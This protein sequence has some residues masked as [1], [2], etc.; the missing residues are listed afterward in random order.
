MNLF[1]YLFWPNPAGWQY[2]DSRV[3]MLLGF[4][5]FLIVLSFAIRYWRRGIKNPITKNLSKSWSAA[6]FWFGIVGIIFVASRVEMIQ[7]L[8]MRA[9]WALWILCI[10]LYVF[11][12]FIQFRRRHY[13]VMQR[14]QVTDERDKYLPKGRG[15][16]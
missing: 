13:T 6:S 12:Q 1:V 9:L 16:K 14:T 3:Q 7:F 5:A 10:G 15:G 8:A 11:F 2:S 4:C